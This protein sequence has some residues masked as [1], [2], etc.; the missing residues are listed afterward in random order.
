M[1]S[2]PEAAAESGSVERSPERKQSAGVA[3][4]QRAW[5]GTLGGFT[6]MTANLGG[7][8]T[9]L[10]FLTLRLDV[11]W[12]LGTT[13][14]FFFVVNLIKLPLSISIGLFSAPLV[15]SMVVLLPVVALG[16]LVGAWLAKRMRSRVF[17]PVVWILTAAGAGALLI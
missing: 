17:D 9:S 10:Y 1:P 12:F 14:W 2:D 7:P 4:A 8:V 11:L 16:A 15:W 13:A 6:T 3:L 5:Y